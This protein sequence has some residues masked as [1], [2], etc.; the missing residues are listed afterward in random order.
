LPALLAI[1][2]AAVVGPETASAQCRYSAE[3]FRGPN[4]PILGPVPT[5]LTGVN[6]L[7][8]AVGYYGFAEAPET[9]FVWSEETGMVTL[10]RVPG[11]VRPHDINDAGQITGG[12][13]AARGFLWDGEQY[14]DLGMPEGADGIDPVAINEQGQIAGRWANITV[15]PTHGFIWENGVMTDLGPILGSANS[16]AADINDGEQIAGSMGTSPVTDF[17]AFILALGAP[18]FVPPLPPGSVTSESRA[19]NALGVLAGRARYIDFDDRPFFRAVVWRNSSFE[20]LPPFDGFRNSDAS[21]VNVHGTT[22]GRNTIPISRAF[23]WQ[24]SVLADLETLI[25]SDSPVPI[26]ILPAAINN[27]GVIV[28]GGNHGATVLTPIF[29]AGDLNRDCKVDLFDL[30]VLLSN[31]GCRTA[32][33]GDV[34]GDAK[35]DLLDLGIMLSNW[36]A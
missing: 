10:P 9:G 1:F 14:I 30:A 18:P 33:E 3:T 27:H 8:Q 5:V 16:N 2:A 20:V 35:V 24:N 28:G 32:C 23:V 13:G 26:R 7:D 29:R 17:R 6:D 15:G 31:F 19:I 36:G 4:D 12:M 11:G 21:G 34:N 25:D 22:I